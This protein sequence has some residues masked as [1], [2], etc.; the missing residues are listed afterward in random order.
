MKVI[1]VREIGLE[2]IVVETGIEAGQQRLE[3]RV[4]RFELRI[5]IR[6]ST[7]TDV[8][9]RR[10]PNPAPGRFLLGSCRKIEIIFEEIG[11]G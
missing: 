4:S 6:A 7:P 9:R 5:S 2:V 8:K 10:L 11:G 3:T 1:G